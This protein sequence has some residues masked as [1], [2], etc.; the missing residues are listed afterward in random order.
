MSN[1][2]LRAEAGKAYKRLVQGTPYLI[3]LISSTV[4][5]V[6]SVIGNGLFGIFGQIFPILILIGLYMARSCNRTGVKMIRVCASIL[7][8]VNCIL[9]GLMLAF[10]VMGVIGSI[11]SNDSQLAAAGA[12]GGILLA[13]YIL[14]QFFFPIFYYRDIRM[15]MKD[16]EGWFVGEQVQAGALPEDS[17]ERFSCRLIILCIIQLI[18][19][20]FTVIYLFASMSGSGLITDMGGGFLN[21]MTGGDSGAQVLR[22][23]IPGPGVFT[24]LAEAAAI[25]KIICVILLYKSY[26]NTELSVPAGGETALSHPVNAVEAELQP[27]HKQQPEP[28]REKKP[29]PEPQRR[30][31]RIILERTSSQKGVFSASMTSQMIVGRKK[32]AANLVIPDD[33]GISGSHMRLFIR[34]NKLYAEDLKSHNGTYVNGRK[35]TEP[36]QIHRGDEIRL[37]NSVFILKWET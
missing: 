11:S 24:V 33:Q 7:F 9:C 18:L 1:R 12:L 22:I 6:L 30:S 25:A 32:D 17:R 5:V 15:I 21:E 13:L 31:V 34:N 3:L 4:T 29:Q 19:H 8:W 20:G 27:Q 16:V 23:L 10:V 2:D 35:M 28:Q 36:S 26:R 14:M 37:G